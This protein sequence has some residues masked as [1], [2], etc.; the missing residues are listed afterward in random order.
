ML[1]ER[2]ILFLGAWT[3]WPTLTAATALTHWS[4]HS[5]S[6]LLLGDSGS[7]APLVK[8]FLLHLEQGHGENVCLQLFS[9][10]IH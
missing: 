3:A 2:I 6:L 4:F 7:L 9:L 5:E 10:D 1:S 8:V